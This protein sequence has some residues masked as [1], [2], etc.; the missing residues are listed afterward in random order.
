MSTIETPRTGSGMDRGTKQV[1]GRDAQGPTKRTARQVVNMMVKTLKRMTLYELAM[2][3]I[4]A[5]AIDTKV[6][7]AIREGFDVGVNA[8]AFVAQETGG[9][10]SELTRRLARGLDVLEA[11]D[12][13]GERRAVRS[14]DDARCLRL[15]LALCSG[16]LRGCAHDSMI[17]DDTNIMRIAEIRCGIRGFDGELNKEW[18]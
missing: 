11:I 3:G 16:M 5:D 13:V 14:I 8:D 4:D 1:P 15:M 7:R 9:A 10:S 17:S 18:K 2:R 12:A 6:L